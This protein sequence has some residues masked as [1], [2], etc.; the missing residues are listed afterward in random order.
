MSALGRWVEAMVMMPA[1]R[2]RATMSRSA[3]VI[4]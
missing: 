2:P 3:A 4:F 1:A